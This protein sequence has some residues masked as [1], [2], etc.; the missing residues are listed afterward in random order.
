MFKYVLYL[1]S[2][3]GL[4]AC[5][6]LPSLTDTSRTEL[7]ERVGILFAQECAGQSACSAHQL[8]GPNLESSYLLTGR[9]SNQMNGQL[10]AVLGKVSTKKTPIT[11]IEVQKIKAITHFDYQTFLSTAAASYVEEH[12]QCTS[13]W[14]QHYAWRLD[15]R[16]PI[17]IVSLTRPL[18]AESATL[19]LEFD[20]VNQTL[21]S[22]NQP[23][24]GASPCRLN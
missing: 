18:H 7:I 15:G 10:I 9:V 14:D 22:A 19:Q 12:Y 20:G 5:G 13:F 23:S 11:T 2:A 16:Q 24:N 21:L 17:L 1:I 6:T 3:A 4:S 8:L